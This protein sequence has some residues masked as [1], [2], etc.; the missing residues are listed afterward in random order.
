MPTAKKYMHCDILGEPFVKNN[1]KYVTI[2]TPFG[3]RK[4]VRWY[5]DVEWNKMYGK[6]TKKVINYRQILGFG[7]AG[8]ITIYYGETYPNLSWFKERPECRYH[9]IFGWYTPSNEEVSNIIPEKVEI[10]K[11]Y[12]DDIKNDIEEIDEEKA[13]VVIDSIR[14]KNVDSGTYV[15]TVGEREVFELTIVKTITMDGY[16]GTSTMHVMKDANENTFIWNTS[17]KTLEVNKTYRMKGTIKEH[18]EYRG[19]KQTVL[20]RCTILK[21]K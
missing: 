8:Y 17:T 2:E 5:S 16:Y 19:V 4:N 12:W 6:S 13:S 14:Y 11:L 21:D 1:R 3:D 9:K 15:G 10:A 20:T 18:K 7:E